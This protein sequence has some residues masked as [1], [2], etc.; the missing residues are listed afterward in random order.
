MNGGVDGWENT[1]L[2]ARA[3]VTGAARFMSDLVFPGLLRGLVVRSPHPHALIRAIDTAGAASVP[4][5]TVLTHRDVPGLNGYGIA[6]PDQPVLCWDKVR[7]VGDPVALVLA[8]DLDRARRAAALVGVA[9]E[10]LPVVDDPAEALYDRPARVHDGGNV[11]L[12]TVAG[13]GDAAG[14]LA[15]ADIVVENTY[16]TQRQMHS[17]LETE[18]GVARPAPD[19]ILEVYCGSHHPYRDRSQIARSLNLPEDL[20]RVVANPVGGSFGGKDEITV[21]ILLGLGVLKTGRPVRIVLSREESVLCG[22]K[23]HP[24][25]IRMK[26][27]ARAD[28]TLVANEVTI[29]A[30]T[31]AYASLGGPILNL[32]VEHACGAYRVPNVAVEG[33]SV[34]TNNG[35]SGPFRGFGVNQVTFAMETQVELVARRAGRDSLAVRRQNVLERDDLGALGHRLVASLGTGV[36][37]DA[38]A[39]TREWREREQW[40]GESPHPWVKRGVGLACAIQGVGLG[41]GLPDYALASL[42]LR[43]DGR[44]LA[45]VS[46]SDVGQGNGAAL[47]RIAAEALG[48]GPAEVDVVTGDTGRAPDSGSATASRSIYAA[49]NALV[50]AAAILA[51]RISLRASAVLGV[52]PGHLACKPGG[53]GP[54]DGEVLLG[55]R[56]AAAGLSRSEATATGYFHFPVAAKEVPGAFGLPHLIYSAMSHLARVEVDTLTGQVSVERIVAVPDAGRVVDPPGLA[57]QA[58][59]GAVMGLGYALCEDLV[60]EN[61]RAKTTDFGTYIL[62]TALDS[63]PVRVLPV[64]GWE[65]SGPF[66]AKGVGEIVAVS[67][68]PAITNAVFD[69]VG[70]PLF[71]LPA[72]GEAVLRALAGEGG[73]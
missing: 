68:T 27:G 63:P 6:V 28:G 56:E 46:A 70:R 73:G 66:G 34:Y 59:G 57:G 45:G 53:L 43:E 31:G 58:H 32:A 21:Q 62:P 48:C 29:L 50:M 30:D 49:G 60:M 15:A 35:V 36:T 24:M 20:I 67:V 55:Y 64:E 51:R 69:A 38:V 25:T 23:R 1:P 2:S 13:S 19:G 42:E 3:K 47:A 26:T 10:L 37:L 18:G 5:V 17:Y 41:R 14:A 39:G 4:G 54:P 12:H 16:H 8:P 11:L 71:G 52:P 22:H 61:G 72:G 40:K 9:Y 44:F 7:F 65:D 33:W